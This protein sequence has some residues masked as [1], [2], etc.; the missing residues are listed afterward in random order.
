[1]RLEAHIQKL[2]ADGV[3][4]VDFSTGHVFSTKSNT[5]E[6]PL[7]AKT[8]KGYI[9]L[10]VSL[11]GVQ[12]HGLAHRIVWIAAHGL[13]PAGMQVDHLDAIKNNNRLSNLS[14]VSQAENM[15][16]AALMGLCT[17][18]RRDGER[19]PTTGRFVGKAH[20]GRMLDGIAHDGF[21]S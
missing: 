21:P 20:A 4:K 1:M 18:G 10:C 11:D 16:R 7:G 2:L 3:I 15:R 19:C 13:I 12:F 17:G 14:L 5:P 8:R 6:R 9:R